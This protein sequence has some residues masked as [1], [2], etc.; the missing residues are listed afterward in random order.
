MSR[1]VPT[2]YVLH[3]DDE[4]SRKAEVQNMRSRMGDPGTAELNTSTFDGR[5]AT[6]A[7]VLAAASS[8]PFLADKRL[9]IVD[10]M[11][12]WLTRKG[13]GK[14][15]KGEL[16]TLATALPNLPDYA[17]LVFVE[18]E[19]LNDSNP[20]LKLVKQEPRGYI[21]AFN[22]P[23]DT[24]HWI[25]KQV[26][27]YGG[28]IE[29]RAASALAAVVGADL[30]AADSECI[31]LVTYAGTDR[32]ISEADV[33]LLTPYVAEAKIFDMVDALGKRDANT[34]ARL[35]RRL[36]EDQDP[37]SLLPMIYRQFRLLIQAREA[38]D[39]GG[40]KRD[41]MKFPDFKSDFV[42]QKAIE[43]ARNFDM[44]QLESIY[45]FLLETDHHIKTGKITDSLALDLL[46]A[47]LA[48]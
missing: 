41:L 6:A 24:T 40:D 46:V 5:N 36:M 20:I 48:A 26:Q 13:A 43:Q 10:G 14:S 44:P 12:S 1:T 19:T 25:T 42:A 22:P 28:T 3:G 18:S 29:P 32:A 47:G 9:V 31:K 37:M 34:A 4:F 38:L 39:A 27:A 30:R 33:A 17:R 23:R 45:R 21:K 16:D 35:I 2:F 8:M 11:L 7:E 15:A